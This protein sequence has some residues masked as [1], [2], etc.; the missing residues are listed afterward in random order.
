MGGLAVNFLGVGLFPFCL[1]GSMIRALFVVLI[2]SLLGLIF[3]AAFNAGLSFAALMRLSAVGMTASVYVSTGLEIAGI[4]VPFWFFIT[5]GVTT[6]YVALGAK[7]AG[8]T[9]LPDD[10]RIERRPTRD[11]YDGY[12][13]GPRRDPQDGNEGGIRR[14]PH[15]RLR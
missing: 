11:G 14:D 12:D 7:A 1:F 10:A 8:P 15:D 2:A 4:S 13:D 5:V 9:P 6:A 3:N